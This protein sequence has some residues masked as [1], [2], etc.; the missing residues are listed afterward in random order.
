MELEKEWFCE[1]CGS[2]LNRQPGFTEQ[3]GDFWM[4]WNCY[5]ENFIEGSTYGEE[6]SFLSADKES[7]EN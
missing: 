2:L 1:E 3:C 6:D 5:H 7:A 4:C